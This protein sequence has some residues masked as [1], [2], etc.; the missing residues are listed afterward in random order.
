MLVWFSL[1]SYVFEDEVV[2]FSWDSSSSIK[3]FT[4]RS[5][6]SCLEIF[7]WKLG[8]TEV[9]KKTNFWV[10]QTVAF[11]EYLPGTPKSTS[12]KWMLG[13]FP[14]ISLHPTDSEPFAFPTLGV[15]R[16]LFFW[17]LPT[18]KCASHVQIWFMIRLK[19][20]CISKWMEASCSW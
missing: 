13:W 4:F 5:E 8:Q 3:H 19:Q 17:K 1:G 2:F 7:R 15:G 12:L 11:G 6:V 18:D 14:T 20:P 9:W 16:W 10:Y